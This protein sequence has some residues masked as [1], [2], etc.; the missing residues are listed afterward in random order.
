M[1]LG[2]RNGYL[3]NG[4]LKNPKL[5]DLIF[6]IRFG[7]LSGSKADKKLAALQ[8]TIE[9][10]SFPAPQHPDLP[11][12]SV[13]RIIS[14]SSER[15]KSV[16]EERI[17]LFGYV[18]HVRPKLSY[19]GEDFAH[20]ELKYRRPG[21]LVAIS[22]ADFKSFL[23]N[24][25]VAG[26][27]EPITDP[28]KIRNIIGHAMRIAENEPEITAWGFPSR[29]QNEYCV[30]GVNRVS[31]QHLMKARLFNPK[32]LIFL[33]WNAKAPGCFLNTNYLE[34]VSRPLAEQAAGGGVGVCNLLDRTFY[35]QS[36]TGT[37]NY[38]KQPEWQS[39]RAELVQL[40]GEKILNRVV[41][42]YVIKGRT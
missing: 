20:I 4:K 23:K 35:G 30:S 1:P 34:D 5:P 41:K 33:R 9:R 12:F 37:D 22:D 26:A 31:V 36:I 28:Q 8:T 14:V 27:D 18:V 38:R 16:I 40:Y 25:S 21:A 6:V 7:G 10:F 39:A 17:N 2:Q 11:Q 15:E 3:P 13:Q 19:R 42:P 24:G 32:G 29:I